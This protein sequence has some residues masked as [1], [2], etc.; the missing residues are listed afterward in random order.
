[1]GSKLATLRPGV[2]GL[3]LSDDWSGR[4]EDEPCCH[5][6]LGPVRNDE[7]LARLTFQRTKEPLHYK[8]IQRKELFPRDNAFSNVCGAQDGMSVDRSSDLSNQQLIDRSEVHARRGNHRL[9][10]GA[11]VAD[12]G[13][14]R[15]IHSPSGEC[16][17]RIY[18]DPLQDNDEHAVIR[19][20]ILVPEEERTFV[21][22][23]LEEL[24]ARTRRP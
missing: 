5:G 11:Y 8:W 1:M 7:Q 16:A 15:A 12:A 22:I 13:A 17:F 9:G 4:S 6:P 20:R 3:R 2:G 19:G 14:V 23:D 24:F 18:D 10:N 21:M